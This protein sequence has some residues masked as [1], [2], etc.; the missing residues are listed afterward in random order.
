[1]ASML[2][3]PTPYGWYGIFMMEGEE[4]RCSL[5]VSCVE[6]RHNPRGSSEVDMTGRELLDP[7]ACRS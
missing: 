1:M 4:Q 7:T 3:N 2:S 5:P 6:R